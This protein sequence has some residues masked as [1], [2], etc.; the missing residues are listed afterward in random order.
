M[1]EDLYKIPH[2]LEE[3]EF[4]FDTIIDKDVS[5]SSFKQ[6]DFLNCTFNLT[7][8]PN[9]EWKEVIF[10]DCVLQNLNFRK[11]DLGDCTF[12]NCKLIDVYFGSSSLYG[13]N[14]IAK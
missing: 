4:E 5:E 1:L 3:N 9:S 14:F 10:E 2:I 13:F 12:K 6:V 7:S 8:F 11:S